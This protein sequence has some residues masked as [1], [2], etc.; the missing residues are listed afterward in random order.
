MHTCHNL[1][2]ILCLKIKCMCGDCAKALRPQSNKC[3]ICRQPIEELIEI[4]I[5][6]GN[7]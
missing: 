2:I 5:N 1:T 7:Q 6:N 3:L 4:K